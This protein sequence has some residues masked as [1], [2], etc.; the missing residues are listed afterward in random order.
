MVDQVRDDE[1]ATCKPVELKDFIPMS[2]GTD[3]DAIRASVLGHYAGLVVAVGDGVFALLQ[4][5]VHFRFSC[6]SAG[7]KNSKTCC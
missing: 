5:V 1:T 6:I 2:G 7:A 4:M 3:A